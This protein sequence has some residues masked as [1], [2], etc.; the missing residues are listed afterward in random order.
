MKTTLDKPYSPC[1]EGYS[2]VTTRSIELFPWWIQ[3]QA[4]LSDFAP[5]A[6][7]LRLFDLVKSGAGVTDRE[8]QLGVLISAGRAA[9]PSHQARVLA[10]EIWAIRVV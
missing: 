7:D 1:S 2:R 8:E 10:F 9:T 6:D 4:R 3:V 5:L